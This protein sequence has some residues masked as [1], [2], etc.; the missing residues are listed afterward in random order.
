MLKQLQIFV[1]RSI[2][3]HEYGADHN[4]AEHLR[5]YQAM[6]RIIVVRFRKAENSWR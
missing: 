6:Y 4:L 3:I 1:S 2:A 5:V